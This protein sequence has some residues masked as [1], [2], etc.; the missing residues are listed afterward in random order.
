MFANHEKGEDGAAMPAL[1]FALGVVGS[2]FLG[3]QALC[4]LHLS[5]YLMPASVL[6]DDPN[7]GR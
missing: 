4:C 5:A 3:P 2:A 1:P 7:S 6:Q